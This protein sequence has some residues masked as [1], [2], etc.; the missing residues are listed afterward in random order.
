M[1]HVSRPFFGYNRTVNPDGSTAYSPVDVFT[2]LIEHFD[3]IGPLSGY[4]VAYQ[5]SCF[6]DN[7][8]NLSSRS[9][10]NDYKL[11]EFTP[12][13][14]PLRIVHMNAYE[15][16]FESTRYRKRFNEY[17]LYLVN[18][19]TG[20]NFDEWLSRPPYEIELLLNDLREENALNLERADEMARRYRGENPGS[21][22]R[23]SDMVEQLLNSSNMR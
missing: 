11:K 7:L 8:F 16:L 20:F 14:D 19:K 12:A 9:Y 1:G 5:I 6:Y 23:Q 22:D 10:T 4:D 17:R 3:K 13:T 15:G 2:L 21:S 18:E